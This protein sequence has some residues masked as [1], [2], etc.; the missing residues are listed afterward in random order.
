[1][2]DGSLMWE[3][4]ESGRIDDYIDLTRRATDLDDKVRAIEEARESL[5]DLYLRILG[6][7]GG[8]S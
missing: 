5:L 3:A 4:Y 1:V 2:G 8:M 6:S 7:G